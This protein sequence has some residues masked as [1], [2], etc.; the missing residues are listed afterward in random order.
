MNEPLS[1]PSKQRLTSLDVF[2]GI[3]VIMMIFV[4][5]PGSWNYVY[6]PFKHAE[7]NGWTLT[8]TIFPF[9]IF[10]MGVAIPWAFSKKLAEGVS[11]GQLYA[12]ILLRAL[13]LFCFG[14][15]LN[16]LSID[17]LSPNHHWLQDTFYKVRIMGVLQRLAVV[18]AL[19]AILFLH[20]GRRGLLILSAV[21]LIGYGLALFY[22]PF[23]V[24]IDGQ[25]QWISG[26][27]EHGKSLAAYLDATL[28]GQNHVYFRKDVLL[29]Y[30]PE[31]LFSTITAL[32]TCLLGAYVGLYLKTNDSIMRKIVHLLAWGV[33]GLVLGQLTNL[34]IPINKTL[35]SPS[36]VVLMAG[37][38][39][40]VLGLCMFLCDHYKLRF[41]VFTLF[42]KH[43]LFIFMFSGVLA[44]LVLM[45]HV[46]QLR[47]RDWLYQYLLMPPL[48]QYMGSLAYTIGFL[49]I[50][51]LVLWAY[52]ASRSSRR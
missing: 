27:L 24:L 41:P 12:D 3:T 17:L 26:Y 8:D 49:I 37:L 52:E 31:G 39:S 48:G 45:P 35:W 34:L 18:Y 33:C 9:F 4:N 15:L 5:N 10:I 13:K 2:R 6:A 22:L 50:N 20:L 40:L 23:P 44:R 21:L 42:G 46:A 32:V 30:D 1:K 47:L 43:A 14:L 7:W 28:L 25:S 16:L 11:R 36:Y 38:A 51:Y 29:P 19:A